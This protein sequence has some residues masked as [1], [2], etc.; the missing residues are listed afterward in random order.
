MFHS[1]KQY[2]ENLETVPIYSWT[3]TNLEAKECQ[4]ITP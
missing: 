1:E 4:L 3:Q 2:I